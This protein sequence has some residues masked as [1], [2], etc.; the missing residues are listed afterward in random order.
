MNRRK[1]VTNQQRSAMIALRQSV[2]RAIIR[3]H[4][5]DFRTQFGRDMARDYEDALHT[6][7]LRTLWRDILL[8]LARQWTARILT[9]APDPIDARKPSLLA[10]DYVMIRDKAFTALEL[11]RGL[12]AAVTLLVLGSYGLNT[13]AN[14]SYPLSLVYAASIPPDPN[15]IQPVVV[16]PPAAPQSKDYGGMLHATGARPSFEVASIRPSAP[17]P[18]SRYSGI[19]VH[20]DSIQIQGSSIK[21]VIEFAYAVPNDNQFSGGP[22]WIRTDK[23]DITAKPDGAEAIALSKL[24]D[25]ERTMRMRLML[26]SLLEDRFQLKVNFATKDL[27]FFALVVAKDGLKCTHVASAS[28][29]LGAVVL[30][31]PPPPPP[32][33]YVPPAPGH[34]AW[35]EQPM[36]WIPHG[37]P[38][39]LIVA[40]MA[41]QPELGGRIVQ[42][43]TG[44]NGTFNCDVSW[45]R[46]GAD[47]PGPSFFTAIQDQ[48][49]LK[50]QPEH[51]PVEVIVIDHIDRPSEN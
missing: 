7:A 25:A 29:G 10:G 28:D 47:V 3:L 35:R 46:E 44:L 43:K 39:S 14:H 2:Y 38:F 22:S 45:A 11:S 18:E 49:G 16:P 27:P 50:L 12:A 41:R 5:A 17:N 19:T 30:P 42:D 33:G 6:H 40:S 36:H 1:P 48:M 21:D 8:S 23:F 37:W 13:G 31:P 26:Q 4:P 32:P 51:G 34:E 24:S 15:V 20:G 9:A